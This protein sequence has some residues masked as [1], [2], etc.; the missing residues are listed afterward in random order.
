MRRSY[1]LS[2]KYKVIQRALEIQDLNKV[3]RENRLNSRMIYRWI[4]EYKQGKYEVSS[5][6]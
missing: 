5:L 6:I 3:A 2:F 4:K 1:S